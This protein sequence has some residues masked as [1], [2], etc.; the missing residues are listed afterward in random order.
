MTKTRI[1]CWGQ[2]TILLNKQKKDQNMKKDNYRNQI[3]FFL[4]KDV[5]QKFQF[6][7]NYIKIIQNQANLFD[8]LTFLF[9]Y[10]GGR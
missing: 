5:H 3:I 7:L 10:I 1:T 6:F 9:E 2:F 4:F 8:Y